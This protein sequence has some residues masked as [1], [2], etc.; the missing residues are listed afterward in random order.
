MGVAAKRTTRILAAIA[1][2]RRIEHQQRLSPGRIFGR[3]QRPWLTE[4]IHDRAQDATSDDP[5]VAIT[6]IAGEISI[7]E[8]LGVGR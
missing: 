2:G 7:I 5:K 8:Q 1:E 6:L 4:R 3:R